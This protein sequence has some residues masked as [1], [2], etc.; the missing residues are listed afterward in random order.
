MQ[1]ALY[2]N[3]FE[4]RTTSIR[5]GTLQFVGKAFSTSVIVAENK[6]HN[7]QGCV[8]VPVS[9][10]HVLISRACNL[11]LNKKLVAVAAGAVNWDQENLFRDVKNVDSL[12]ENLLVVTL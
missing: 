9:K 12:G 2:F 6:T 11:N 1:H 7:Y 5:W 10:Q 8:G 3:N 4:S